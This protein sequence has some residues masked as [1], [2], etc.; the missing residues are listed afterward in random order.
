MACVWIYM[1]FRTSASLPKLH[2]R[3][4]R[5]ASRVDGL[6]LRAEDHWSRILAVDG[7][8][9]FASAFGNQIVARVTQA[10]FRHA[11]QPDLVA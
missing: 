5:L 1:K 7:G 8:R 3:G 11:L 9:F 2:C 10:Y 4:Q 6:S